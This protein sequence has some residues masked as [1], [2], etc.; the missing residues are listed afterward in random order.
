MTQRIDRQGMF[1]GRLVDFG[2][3]TARSGAVAITVHAEIDA[4]LIDDQWEDWTEFEFD[5]FGDLWVIGRDGQIVEFV[6][7]DL[8]AFAGWDGDLESVVSG[9][10]TPPGLVF[11]VQPNEYEGIIRYK[12][13]RV[14]DPENPVRGTI[15]GVTADEARA[16]QAEYGPALRAV[17][18]DLIE[19]P[20]PAKPKGGRKPPA[21][22]TTVPPDDGGPTDADVPF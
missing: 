9:S 6:A 14:V 20:A 5:V 2:I 1:R 18:G 21:P 16:L 10:W 15:S 19:E 12:L 8:C 11:H 4:A 3:K 13:T 7:R 22:K 17:V